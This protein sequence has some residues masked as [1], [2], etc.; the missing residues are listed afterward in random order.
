MKS[1]S[2]FTDTKE[3]EEEICGEKPTTNK[4][5]LKTKKK[6]AGENERER[7]RETASA[8][9]YGYGSIVWLQMRD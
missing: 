9:T 7:E 5:R 8:F 6:E 4:S 3:E 1:C 2:Y